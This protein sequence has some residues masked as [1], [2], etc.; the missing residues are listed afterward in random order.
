V[1]LP[2]AIQEKKISWYS[3]EDHLT[4]A[5]CLFS[6]EYDGTVVT[7]T[8]LDC[9]HGTG[10]LKLIHRDGVSYSTYPMTQRNGLWLHT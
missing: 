3:E 5:D 1:W 4:M 9:V 6:K 8:A 10:H 7:P 2:L